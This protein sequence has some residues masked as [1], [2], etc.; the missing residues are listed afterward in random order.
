VDLPG[1]EGHQGIGLQTEPFGPCDGGGEAAAEL[2]CS[3]ARDAHL[4]RH[5]EITAGEEGQE[6]VIANPESANVLVQLD[7]VDA[8]A[9][10]QLVDILDLD[11]DSHGSFFPPAGLA[12]QERLRDDNDLSRSA[13]VMS[14]GSKE[15]GLERG[16]IKNIEPVLL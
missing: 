13:G 6:D 4:Q 3:D 11:G 12:D 7:I 10:A 16:G 8:V 9:P 15:C 2:T 5:A 14:A 1:S